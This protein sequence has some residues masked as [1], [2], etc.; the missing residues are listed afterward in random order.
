MKEERFKGLSEEQVARAKACK[1]Q[2]E[3]LKLA[4]E[5][6]IELTDEQ[7]GAVSGGC[8]SVLICSNCR[9]ELVNIFEDG[10][11]EKEGWKHVRC[12]K[13]GNTWWA[14]YWSCL[15]SV[16]T[17]HFANSVFLHERR[18]SAW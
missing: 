7:L 4:K 10:T 9:C 16:N 1:N 8:Q 14:K 12:N 5:E 15:E 17:R 6:G 3:V 2:K 11:G 13:C 18:L